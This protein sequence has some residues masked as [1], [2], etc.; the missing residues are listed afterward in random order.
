MIC[1]VSREEVESEVM[2]VGGH[3]SQDE[4]YAAHAITNK[5][6]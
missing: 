3:S 4:T 1:E 5:R 2:R 6:I